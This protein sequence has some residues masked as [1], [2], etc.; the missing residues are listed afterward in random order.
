M[1]KAQKVETEAS[2]SMAGFQAWARVVKILRRVVKAHEMASAQ[3]RRP[4][5]PGVV[6]RSSEE[7]EGELLRFVGAVEWK[8]L[9]S[10]VQCDVDRVRLIDTTSAKGTIGVA[11]STACKEL[12][13]DQPSG[14]GWREAVGSVDRILHRLSRTST[15]TWVQED[16]RV[17]DLLEEAT[18]YFTVMRSHTIASLYASRAQRREA[19]ALE[20]RALCALNS[21]HVTPEA[22]S[23]GSMES[24]R[25]VDPARDDL[26]VRIRRA[27]VLAHVFSTSSPSKS[28]GLEEAVVEGSTHQDT[29][30]TH[31]WG[32]QGA[33]GGAW[34][35][36]NKHGGQWVEMPMSTS[37]LLPKPI[38][39]DVVYDRVA[40]VPDDV[41]V[42]AG[43][44][45]P[46]R[47]L[48]S[49]SIM[50]TGQGESKKARDTPSRPTAQDE[51]EA[52]SSG[53]LWS[54]LGGR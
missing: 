13:S 54:W 38:F 23:S 42:K 31:L 28:L 17:Q 15:R 8:C 46:P 39:L 22:P 14:L 9:R 37:S 51:P 20:S 25:L 32:Y 43:R 40:Q 50:A 26:A 10:A 53:G 19:Y 45:I 27:K 33:R 2:G 47:P 48:T 11:S 16:A 7:G 52:S 5:G 35:V 4:K 21:L 6:V 29:W 44:A 34:G 1:A 12:G 41:Y 36:G 24:M 49:A 30:P 18:E 3:V